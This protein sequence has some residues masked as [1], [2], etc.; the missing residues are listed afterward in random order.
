MPRSN[1]GR[2]GRNRS[3]INMD[4]W[5]WEFL[6][7]EVTA[8][9]FV[10]TDSGPLFGPVTGFTLVRDEDLNLMLHT[11]S[12]SDSSTRAIERP[13]GSVYISTDEVKLESRLGA[14]ATAMG[15]IPRSYS[16]A[17]TLSTQATVTTQTSSLHSLRW[18]RLEASEPRY[19]MEWV[20]NLS[21]KFIWPHSD[22][23]HETGEKRRTLRS[24]LG[25]LVLSM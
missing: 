12:A 5:D 22:D 7:S 21:G 16:R 25:E 2:S 9:A 17:T 4:S 23:T 14:R 18:E 24:P 8:D 11:T 3:E 1:R 15:V 6:E 19:I 10:V 20:A 13:P